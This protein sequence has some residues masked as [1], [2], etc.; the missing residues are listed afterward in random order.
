MDS[1]SL[2][3]GNNLGILRRYIPDKSV[4]LHLH[5]NFPKEISKDVTGDGHSTPEMAI[6][7]SLMLSSVSR[8]V[9]FADSHHA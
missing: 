5:G 7:S 6:S 9:S 3:Y 4:D 2:D 8:L 1:N